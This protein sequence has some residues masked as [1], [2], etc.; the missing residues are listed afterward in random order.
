MAGAAYVFLRGGDGWTELAK[1]SASDASAS[2]RLSTSVAVSGT[3]AIAG[4]FL[5]S[6]PG[7]VSAGAA[8]IFSVPASGVSAGALGGALTE[9]EFSPMLAFQAEESDSTRKQNSTSEQKLRIDSPGPGPDGVLRIRV[10]GPAGVKIRLQV[11]CDLREWSE[12]T[13]VTLTSTASHFR[14]RAATR[15][16]ARFY[17]VVQIS[18]PPKE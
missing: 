11:S 10:F 13:A 17:R 3:N 6:L 12:L 18:E 16:G 5:A 9:N 7:K 15:A 14:D 2:D 1:L 8:Y 4:A